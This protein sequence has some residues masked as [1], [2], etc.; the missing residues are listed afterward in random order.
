MSKALVYVRHTR[1]RAREM[2][3]HMCKRWC[4]N[5]GHTVVRVVEER[6]KATSLELAH[7]VLE[8]TLDFDLIVAT[9]G[10]QFDRNQAR[11][12]RLIDQAQKAGV[13]L[14]NTDGLEFT[15]AS[16]RFSLQM[17]LAAEEHMNAVGQEQL[18]VLR[19]RRL[20]RVAADLTDA[21]LAGLRGYVG[22]LTPAADRALQKLL[23]GVQE[24]ENPST[25]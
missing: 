12:V 13:R 14:F 10:S 7:N 1:E 8:G 11:M 24:P 9:S 16:Y 20:K 2:H 19:K 3:A 15:S 5:N 23:E 4:E 21:E 18:R 6:G 25:N 17:L 22:K